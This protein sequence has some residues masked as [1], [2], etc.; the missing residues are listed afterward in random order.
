MDTKGDTEM[1][2]ILGYIFGMIFITLISYLFPENI[3]A[4]N[5]RLVERGLAEYNKTTGL[6]EWKEQK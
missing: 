3:R 5:Y 1:K 4:C 6:I 2:F